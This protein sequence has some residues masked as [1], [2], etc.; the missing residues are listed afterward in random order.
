MD[1]NIERFAEFMARMIEKYASEMEEEIGEAVE[2]IEND[3]F[4]QENEN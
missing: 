4:L 1:I 3:E 2:P